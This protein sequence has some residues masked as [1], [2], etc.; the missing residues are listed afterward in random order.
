MIK[1]KQNVSRIALVAALAFALTATLAASGAAAECAI[2]AA[3]VIY[4]APQQACLTGWISAPASFEIDA[5][6]KL[7]GSQALDYLAE[8]LEKKGMSAS[9][10]DGAGLISFEFGGP[11]H[12]TV[13]RQE[14][15]RI[16]VSAG[17]RSEIKI[18]ARTGAGFF[19]AA[20][21]L[22]QLIAKG[23]AKLAAGE[24]IDFPAFSYRGVLEGG[25]SVWS[26]EK[27][28]AIIEWTGKMKMNS[29]IYAPKEGMY[30]RR[31]WRAP[32][33][34]EEM[35]WF[36][37]YVEASA[38]NHVEFA[39]SLSP[40]MSM[41]YSDP[42]EFEV[43]AAKYARMQEIGVRRFGIFFDDVLPYLSTPADRAAYKNIAE[44]E[45]E[46]TNK[47]LDALRERDRD[48]KLFFVPNQYWGWT[49]TDYMR[50][51]RE[52]LHPDIDIG[53]TGR[54]IVSNSIPADDVRE[55]IKLV[56]RPPA[57][58]DNWSP[59]GPVERRDPDIYKLT[60]SYLNNPYGFADDSRA[61]MSRFVD[62]TVADYGWNPEAYDP[63]RSIRRASEIIA[64]GQPAGD[65]LL[66]ALLIKG[67]KVS[68]AN[69]A[70]I[71]ALLESLSDASKAAGSA[72]SL[73]ELLNSYSS[74]LP[75]AELSPMFAAEVAP[76][77]EKGLDAFS[78]ASAA[79]ASMSL[80]AD[81]ASIDDI[82]KI[83]GLKK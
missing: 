30:F 82:K 36:K 23:G 45:V 38:R 65:A 47:L 63:A 74:A 43:L 28:L 1:V 24:V 41:E 75:A 80:P 21:T 69:I 8:A 59:L 3:A 25:Y 72:A 9:P 29:F 37:Q 5:D 20:L 55:F 2:D 52:K 18:S 60:S 39:Y 56:G 11:E 13:F 83:L 70:H 19:Y 16:E 12:E 71:P 62:S 6:E 15:Y 14:G 67:E 46:V 7:V 51:V 10:A 17:D 78:R 4:P 79:L 27:R 81:S 73:R 57:I 58:G 54:D 53:W 77:L 49:P 22:E 76:A 40:A 32:H 61:K 33:P 42:A 34:D 31:R 44:A 50:I 48:V 64:G 68:P 26:H 35:E 66:L